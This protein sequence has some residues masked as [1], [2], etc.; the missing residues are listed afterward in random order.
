MQCPECGSTNI[1]RNGK[2]K[3]KQNHICKECIRQFFGTYSPPAGYS[4]EFKCECLRLYVNGLGF[5]A[6]ERVKGVHHTTVITV[7][8]APIAA[9]CCW[10]DSMLT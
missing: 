6:I 10:S 5:R 1:S 9:N 3:G 8:V 2:Q 7:A 4:D